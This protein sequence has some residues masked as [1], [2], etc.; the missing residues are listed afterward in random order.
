MTF[1]A[2][3]FEQRFILNCNIIMFSLYGIITAAEFIVEQAEV[4]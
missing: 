4:A 3:Y 2:L 1:Y